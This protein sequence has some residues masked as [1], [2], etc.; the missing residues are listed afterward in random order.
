MLCNEGLGAVY[1]GAGLAS[2]GGIGNSSTRI[3]AAAQPFLL[4]Y[5]NA[6]RLSIEDNFIVAEGVA[7]KR[8][9]VHSIVRLALGSNDTAVSI[10]ELLE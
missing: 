2:M 5:C 10:D 4:K 6:A 8:I 9:D 1:E 3:S 7:N